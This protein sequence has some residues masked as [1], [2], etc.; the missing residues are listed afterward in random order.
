MSSNISGKIQA[1]YFAPSTLQHTS[2]SYTAQTKLCVQD[3]LTYISPDIALDDGYLDIIYGLAALALSYGWPVDEVRDIGVTWASSRRQALEFY[4]DR[5]V[6]APLPAKEQ[7]G[8]WR[9]VAT[10]ADQNGWFNIAAVMTE[11]QCEVALRKIDA[12]KAGRSMTAPAM[13]Y[14]YVIRG[15]AAQAYYAASS[16][17][18][19]SPPPVQPAQATASRTQA[20]GDSRRSASPDVASHRAV[21]LP[22]PTGGT[23]I[24]WKAPQPIEAPLLPVAKFDADTMLPQAL[25]AWVKDA[26]GGIPCTPD[27]MAVAAVTAAGSLIGARCAIK[28]KEKADWVVVP[29]L[30]GAVVGMPSKGKSPAISEALKPVKKLAAQADE[31]HKVALEAFRIKNIALAAEREWREEA[32]KKLVKGKPTAKDEQSGAV[33]SVDQLEKALLDF[34]ASIPEGP[35]K[36]RFV[37]NDTTAEKLGELLK[38]N[39]AGIL[40]VADELVGLLSSWDREGREGTR[41]FFLEA[42]T[43]TE[44]YN[45]DRIGRGEILIPNLIV[46]LVGGIQP[47]KLYAYLEQAS[48]AL[49]NDGLLQ[50]FQVLVYPDSDAWSYQDRYADKEARDAAYKAYETLATLDPVARGANSADE[51]NKFPYFRFEAAAQK[52]YVAWTTARA[53]RAEKAENDGE[54][55]MAQHLGKYE[56]LFAALSLI[57]HLL[58]GDHGP[59][60]EKAALM[61]EA[62]CNYLETH[63]RRC[64][65][66]LLDG[67]LRGAQLISKALK[68]GALPDGF[69]ARDIKQ[70]WRTLRKD[71]D[72]EAA[73]EWL[74]KAGWLFEVAEKP[75]ASGGRPSSKYR[76]NPAVFMSL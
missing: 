65:G 1:K 60:T 9:K 2:R 72:T 66:L 44:P 53:A 64:Y 28:P 7:N 4:F 31:E 69:T 76:I 5:A 57:F 10:R 68:K 19:A 24:S 29:N 59:V 32:I 47:D 17:Y 46:S 20:S 51:F 12:A 50:R 13:D 26:T 21:E 70:K 54:T 16:D 25:R 15:A 49:A 39:P 41:Q 55:L 56:K 52:V 74:I 35:K 34:N 43:G 75:G 11:S 63:A 27:Y 61:A 6:A 48:D 36:R 30:W 3:A 73:L 38:D 71:G 67:G 14:T 33:A 42:W 18:M 45:T 22:S 40:V 58:N 62:W 8:A 23:Y 37:T